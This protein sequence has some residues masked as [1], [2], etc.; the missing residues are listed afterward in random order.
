MN[1]RREVKLFPLFIF[2]YS[3][4]NRV[5]G[6]IPL[7]T[8]LL[9]SLMLRLVANSYQIVRSFISSSKRAIITQVL[10]EIYSSSD[11]FKNQMYL[12]IRRNA[13]FFQILLKPR[14]ETFSK[15]SSLLIL[16]AYSMSQSARKFKTGRVHCQ[17]VFRIALSCDL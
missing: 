16:S 14:H 3:Q 4:G 10:L 2:S 8:I 13:T 17:L 15:G 6:Y 5:N 1:R 9:T 7:E 11:C 12:R